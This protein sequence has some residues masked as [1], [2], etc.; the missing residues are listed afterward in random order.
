[1]LLKLVKLLGEI[2]FGLY[3]FVHVL[4]YLSPQTAR[5]FIFQ[6]MGIRQLVRKTYEIIKFISI[7]FK[8]IGHQI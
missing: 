5:Y 1:M 6:N 8:L 2:Y 7:W 4:F 3:A